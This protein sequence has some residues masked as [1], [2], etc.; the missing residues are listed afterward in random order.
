VD[1]AVRGRLLGRFLKDKKIGT[2]L[3][4]LI[5]RNADGK[6]HSDNRRISAIRRMSIVHGY[7]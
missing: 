3:T 5:N 7:P 1:F 4:D 6:V 2:K